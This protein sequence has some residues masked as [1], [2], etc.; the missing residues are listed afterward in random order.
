MTVQLVKYASIIGCATYATRKLLNRRRPLPRGGKVLL[1]LFFALEVLVTCLLRQYFSWVSIFAMVGFS[2]CLHWILG[3]DNLGGVI[4]ATILGHGI[5][6]LCFSVGLISIVCLYALGIRAFGDVTSYN[7]TVIGVIQMAGVF[8]LFRIK[9]L[10]HGLPFL[11]D[12]QYGDIGVYLSV[13]VLMAASLGG[14]MPADNLV[15]LFIFYTLI[16]CGMSLW[17][18]WKRRMEREYMDQ[19]RKREQARLRAAVT[20][21]QDQVAVLRAENETFSRIIHRDNKL[22]PAMELAVRELLQAAGQGPIQRETAQAML[23][24]L[25]QLSR[26][27]TGVVRGY[28]QAGVSLPRTGVA[29]LDA[30]FAYLGQKAAGSGITLRLCLPV[31]TPALLRIA[32]PEQDAATLLAD[33]VENAIIAVRATGGPGRVLVELVQEEDCPSIRVSDSGVPFPAEV[34]A[35]WGV[36]RMT[37]HGDEGGSGIGLIST[38][39]LCQRHRASFSVQALPPGGPYTKTVTVRFDGGR[40]FHMAG[41]EG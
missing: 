5:S 4:T 21:L 24:Q 38:Y 6:Y 7:A 31:D 16:I 23:A 9:R 22:I 12:S 25:A 39:E 2:I 37:T 19:I 8:L 40:G 10:R 28:E 1:I 15:A 20:A 33:L 17:F 32:L 14:T 26:E 41:P 29:V 11:A 13:T 27:R 3:R 35:N 36:R 18:W 30:L 34:A